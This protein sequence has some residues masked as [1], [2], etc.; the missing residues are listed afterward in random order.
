MTDLRFLLCAVL[1]VAC[2]GASADPDAGR[3]EDGGRTADAG[4]TEDAGPGEDAGRAEDAG[5]P[6]RDAGGGGDDAGRAPCGTGQPD[7][8]TVRN[9]EGLVIAR[10]GTIYFSRR[11]AVGRVTPDGTVD[12]AWAS[13]GGGSTTVWGLALDPSNGDVYVGVPGMGVLVIGVSEPPSSRV[14]V[15]GGAPNGLTWGPDGLLYYSDFSEGHVYRVERT[16]GTPSRVTTSVIRGANGVA[17]EAG[18]T[19]L[20]ASYM[21]GDLLRLTLGGSGVETGRETVVSTLGN[22]DG[23]ALDST[24]RIYVTD[25]GTGEVLRFA[26]DG[27]GRTPLGTTGAP[28]N[29]E[30]GVGALRCSDLYVTSGSGALLRI[31]TDTTGAA[32]PWH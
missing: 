20:V 27:T 17:F 11:G 21:D 19:L 6:P 14:L 23:I 22:P 2:D 9:T 10:D 24:G 3:A 29:L 18:G 32:V 30:F 25:Q 12:S 1:I 15:A 31:E 26:S 16:G 5:T 28:A 8:S 7:V 4:R 13:V